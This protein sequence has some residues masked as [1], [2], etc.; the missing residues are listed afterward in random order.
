MAIIVRSREQGAKRDAI[1]E[2]YLALAHFDY[3]TLASYITH[4]YPWQKGNKSI[5]RSKNARFSRG[6]NT[7]CENGNSLSSSVCLLVP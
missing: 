1:E 5:L 7:M 6:Q 2:G 4:I 3:Q